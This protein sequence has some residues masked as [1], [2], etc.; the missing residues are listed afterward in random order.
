MAREKNF[1]NRI[2][3]FLREQGAWF[4]KYWGGG[5]FT[6]SGVPDILCCFE[7]HFLGIEVKAEHGK[8]SILQLY[9]LR[10]IDEA[11]GIA[12]LLYPKDFDKFR[13]M[14]QYIHDYGFTDAQSIYN[15]LKG[16][17]SDDQ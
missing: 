15:E 11:G 10:K 9:N 6:K 16:V 4:V 7:G 5:E 12:V 3:T 17:W 2:K 14:I 1:E 13:L 8:P